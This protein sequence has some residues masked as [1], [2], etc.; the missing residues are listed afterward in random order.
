MGVYPGPQTNEWGFVLVSSMSEAICQASA[1]TESFV[2][3]WDERLLYSPDLW[4]L[5]RFWGIS[6]QLILFFITAY[7]GSLYV[8]LYVHG[9]GCGCTCV[10]GLWVRRAARGGSRRARVRPKTQAE[11]RQQQSAVGHNP[12]ML[13]TVAL[14]SRMGYGC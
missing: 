7:I 10:F 12:L 11:L 4:V 13:V 1:H 6:K 5:R 8:E 9:C 3:F 14:L 2:G